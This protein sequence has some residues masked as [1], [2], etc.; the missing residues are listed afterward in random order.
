MKQCFSFCLATFRNER[1]LF[2]TTLTKLC[3]SL[4]IWFLSLSWTS[5]WDNLNN[6]ILF[7]V[8][9]LLV[10]LVTKYLLSTCSAR[11]S[12]L[13]VWDAKCGKDYRSNYTWYTPHILLSTP[14][15]PKLLECHHS[16]T[17]FREWISFIPIQYVLCQTH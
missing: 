8:I 16:Y 6:I 2:S 12:V 9:C 7:F 1:F 4:F 17:T 15:L 10:C 14:H 11:Y 13:G 3:L 5:F